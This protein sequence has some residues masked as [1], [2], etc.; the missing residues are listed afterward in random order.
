MA[1][2]DLNKNIEFLW[3]LLKLKTAPKFISGDSIQNPKPKTQNPKSK[4]I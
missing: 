4:T 1:L 2:R 3:E